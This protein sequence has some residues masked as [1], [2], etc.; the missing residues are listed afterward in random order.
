[1]ILANGVIVDDNFKLRSCDLRIE[2]EMI[3]EIG[4]GHGDK[5]GIEKKAYDA[6]LTENV[7]KFISY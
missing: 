6:L 5:K 1:M 3:A 2:G 7:K 4:Q